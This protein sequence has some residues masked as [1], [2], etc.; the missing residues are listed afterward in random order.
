MFAD[1]LLNEIKKWKGNLPFDFSKREVVL[2][3]LKFLYWTCKASEQLLIDGAH[4]AFKYEDEFTVGLG[5]YYQEHF[6]EEKDELKVLVKDLAN[7]GV[8]VEDLKL[9]KLA[10]ALIGSQYYMLKHSHP[11]SLLGY[12]AIQEADPTPMKV[13]KLLE[14]AHGKEILSF[15]RMHA[16][17]DLEHRKELI[18]I[19]D[20]IPE[21]KKK[22]VCESAENVMGYMGVLS[23]KLKRV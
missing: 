16:I 13:V 20:T 17:K 19:L 2:E 11:V 15:L 6:H 21:D 10:M 5:E 23:K 22:L 7:A 8:K 4:Q 9:D 18:E 3:N 14:E 1:Y 12:M